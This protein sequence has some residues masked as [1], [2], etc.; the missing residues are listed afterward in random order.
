[1]NWWLILGIIAGCYLVKF[2]W[3]AYNHPSHTLGR[4]AAN[5]NWVA[6]GRVEDANGYK[7]IKV[8]RDGMEAIISFKKGNVILAKPSHPHPFN[9]FIEVERWLATSTNSTNASDKKPDEKELKY[10]EDINLFI[11]NAGHYE[12]VLEI[13]GADKEFCIASLK[14]HNSGYLT[15]QPANVVSALTIT[16]AKKHN[17]DRLNSIVFLEIIAK[18]FYDDESDN[19]ENADDYHTLLDEAVSKTIGFLNDNGLYKSKDTAVMSTAIFSELI[20]YSAVYAAKV[21]NSM[22]VSQGG[23]S[24]F[25]SSIENRI[26]ATLEKPPSLSEHEK[27]LEV[28]IFTSYVSNYHSEMDQIERFFDE[29]MAIDKLITHFLEIFGEPSLEKS[30]LIR[31]HIIDISEE[32]GYNIVEMAIRAFD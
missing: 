4:Q 14:M 11:T 32:Y 24:S 5:M 20:V 17:E 13:Q 8:S 19:D 3:R 22:E 1:M 27:T 15:G 2:L 10:Y 31:I 25:K 18:N 21:I 23:W 9:D 29:D 30:N 12:Y 6:V 7:N 26:L 28:K 16:A